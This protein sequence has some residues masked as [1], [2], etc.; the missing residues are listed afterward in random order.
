MSAPWP[1]L[2]CGLVAILRGLTPDEAVAVASAVHEAGIEAIEV[3]L[4]SPEPFRSIEAIAKALP[5]GLVGAGTVLAAAEVD[6]LNRAGGKLLV[7]PN[8]DPS[9]LKRAGEYGMVTMPGVFTPTEAFLALKSGASALK[10]FPASALGA[11]GINAIRA[12]LPKETVIGAVGG[13]SDADFST[14]KAAGVTAFG[15]G[16]SLY[17]PGQSEQETGRKAVAAVAEYRRV[18][19]EE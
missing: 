16:S 5:N 8:V 13:I 4:N 15:L 3:P 9:V 17:K 1:K 11:S 6:A 2:K 12:V 10:F 7:S 19:G 14:Y 18:F